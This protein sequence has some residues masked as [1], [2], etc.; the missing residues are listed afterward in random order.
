MDNQAWV[1][2]LVL[3]ERG[4]TSVFML[5]ASVPPLWSWGCWST[6]ARR[7]R[8]LLQGTGSVAVVPGWGTVLLLNIPNTWDNTHTLETPW[9]RAA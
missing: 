6:G 4:Q 9:G 3:P 1:P 7:G 8:V 5:W 2:V